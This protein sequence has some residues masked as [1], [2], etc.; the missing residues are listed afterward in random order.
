MSDTP[1]FTEFDPT[2]IPSHR[3]LTEL[4][5][6][7]DYSLGVHEI[8]LSGTVG[9]AK[10]LI[11]VYKIIDHC[12][13]YSDARVLF[14][15]KNMPDLK[16]TMIYTAL[17]MLEGT[18]MRVNGR[19]NYFQEGVHYFHNKQQA[20]IEFLNGAIIRSRSWADKKFKK[21]RSHPY[22]AA[23]IEEITE[24]DNEECEGFH[25][26]MLSRVGRVNPLNSNVKENFVLYPTNAD[27]PEHFAYKYF[28]KPEKDI[29]NTNRHV[30]YSHTKDN[31]FIPKSYFINLRKNLSPI[32]A[33]RK[34]SNQWI[35]DP[36][37]V[38]YYCYDDKKHYK[39][40]AYEINRKHPIHFTWDFNI[41]E[42]KPLSLTAF[43]FI[44]DHFHFFDEVIIYGSS[45][46]ESCEEL[47]GKNLL[48]NK[49]K[50]Y[51][52]GDA[53]GKARATKSLKSDYDIIRH[54]FANHRENLQ[55]EI[56]IP[57]INPPIKTRHNR[58]NTYLKNDLGDLRVSVYPK[59]KT[60]R[61]G[62]KLTALKK[63]GSYIEDD[64][65]YYQHV[66]TAMGYGIYY[67]S[68]KL[69]KQGVTIKVH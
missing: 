64:S 60:L 25:P 69:N 61:D 39:D 46:Q 10:S 14:G 59:C 40:V 49:Y 62:L 22:S 4:M 6:D 24:N 27:S 12:F 5:D 44:K 47:D 56:K 38:I 29:D 54:F 43:Q 9:S 37:S 3:E 63:G 65:K 13:K 31:P 48:K 34:L 19:L 16:D 32:E 20:S 7:L 18:E 57:T 66:T 50:Y 67:C 53:T 36:K 42:G 28:I 26:E 8:L 51:I 35:L 15:R 41:G 23:Y 21:L 58:V 52:H 1:T 68:E 55:F 17:E 45:T 11:A 2:I 33:A 30:I